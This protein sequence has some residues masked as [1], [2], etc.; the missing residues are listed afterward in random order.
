MKS[1][2]SIHYRI[3]TAEKAVDL[4]FV[5]ICLCLIAAAAA[6][7]LTRADSSK[8]V[9][10]SLV[11]NTFQ[12]GSTDLSTNGQVSVLQKFLLSQQFFGT[13][14]PVTAGYFGTS[15][16]TSLKAFQKA[17]NLPPTGVTDIP[18]RAAIS[19]VCASAPIV[20][21]PPEATLDIASSTSL[22]AAPR[23]SGSAENL[24]A[25][26][27]LTL[28]PTD[29]ARA[30]Q[31]AYANISVPI[32]AGR[33]SMTVPPLLNGAYRVNVS[34]G[35]VLLQSGVITVGLKSFPRVELDS[36][37]PQ[38][39]VA[40]G[41]LMRFK[42][43]APQSGSITIAQFGFAMT[44]ESADVSALNLY[45]YT[46]P[47]Y[48]QPVATSTGG[49]LNAEPLDFAASF[50]LPLLPVLYIPAGETYYF[51]LDGT[52]APSD[53]VYS[54]ATT[55]LGDSA[56]TTLGS[57]G[58]FAASNNIVWSPNT[59][60]IPADTDTD[61]INGSFV[62]GIPQNGLQET[63]INA[64]APQTPDCTMSADTD[65]AL[66]GQHI[67]ITWSSSDTSSS[68]WDD[69]TK[70]AV[71]GTKVFIAPSA[72]HTYTLTFSGP[73]GAAACTATVVVLKPSTVVT[74]VK[75][76]TTTTAT[77]TTT[78]TATT[79]TTTAT[80]TPPTATTTPDTFSAT[81]I[82]GMVP[83]AV[84]FKGSV[85]N[86]NS[87]ATSTYSLVYGDGN[88]S[89][90]VVGAKVCKVQTFS[91]AHTYSKVGTYTSGLYL[92]AYTG[93]GTTTAKL[94]QTQVITV[95]AKT[96]WIDT[97]QNVASAVSAYRGV[98][99]ALVQNSFH[100]FGW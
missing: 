38:S 11:V 8:N 27:Q 69:G 30:N 25:P 72:T 87:C 14:T 2:Q 61:W 49:L 88:A 15:T 78:T 42:V 57:A 1:S 54:V 39:D 58:T 91:F 62:E 79:T 59:Y 80:T 35:G 16:Q 73:D 21:A 86:S 94:L 45:A 28:T 31:I 24:T 95:K 13:S 3:S 63:R 96:A 90:V 32:R 26:L 23:I 20:I 12:L 89:Q 83:F 98:I 34:S 67:T 22:L 100:L 33:W 60:G 43:T 5:G 76:A 53:T 74:I 10:C 93:T 36:S 99:S 17:E 71:S 46:D 7:F 97:M 44:T 68:V 65:T 47:D 64:P 50:S 70:D 77:T 4:F 55:L 51:E 85:N 75:V 9:Q 82:S 29:I 66:P 48:S 84:A 56:T 37:L 18:T 92:G 41:R 52:V 81:P 6:P 19:R 40:D